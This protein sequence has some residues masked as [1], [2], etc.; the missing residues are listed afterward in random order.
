MPSSWRIRCFWRRHRTRVNRRRAPSA[1]TVAVQ[2]ISMT[3]LEAF[4]IRAGCAGSFHDKIEKK[5]TV[6]MRQFIQ[7]T[8]ED[9]EALEIRAIGRC[10]RYRAQ[11][12]PP[13][14]TPTHKAVGFEI[15][16]LTEAAVL[17]VE[18]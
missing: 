4:P 1:R 17:Y 9:F 7:G 16:P 10:L 12:M 11:E 3:R 6:A 8:D 18:R 5:G 14:C 15:N 13:G 2:V